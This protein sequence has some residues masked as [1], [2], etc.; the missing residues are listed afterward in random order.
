MYI[1]KS[2]ILMVVL[3]FTSVLNLQAQ[4]FI[5]E[6]T[7]L[8]GDDDSKMTAKNKAIL[9]AKRE[10]IEKA[11]VYVS[12]YSKSISGILKNDTIESFSASIMK[13]TLLENK[14]E[15][16]NY[17][18]KIEADI[19]IKLL[20]KKIEQ[21]NNSTVHVE[22]QIQSTRDEIKEYNNQLKQLIK[23]RNKKKE[24]KNLQEIKKILI[25]TVTDLAQNKDIELQLLKDKSYAY[26][27]ISSNIKDSEIYINDAY[28]GI[29]PIKHFKVQS[30]EEIT[31]KGINDKRYYPDDVIFKDKFKKLSVSEINL[32]FKKG[33]A[34]LFFIGKDNST[35]YINDTIKQKLNKDE[36]VVIVEAS[37]DLMIGIS[38]KDGCFISNED[39]W[40]NST[41]EIFFT[42]DRQRCSMIKNSLIHKGKVYKM[43][44]SPYTKRVW[45]N[46][47]LGASRVCQSFDDKSCYG[48]YFQWGRSGDGHEKANSSTTRE[49]ASSKNP[50]NSMFIISNKENNHNWLSDKENNLWQLNQINNPCP[51][52][53]RV[54]T[55]DE[56]LAEMPKNKDNFLKL[57]HAGYRYRK[58]GSLN[59]QN[60]STHIWSSSIDKGYSKSLYIDK[61][62]IEV[63]RSL[64][65][66]GYS[67][68]CIKE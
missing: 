3:I 62:T 57:P 58:D 4:I 12:S 56:L 30:D 26:L 68:R 24:L 39:V 38:H 1:N 41:Y 46:K 44:V 55:I 42:L 27:N 35:L 15:Y 25:Q 31:I 34:E 67:L 40:A 54:P 18:V 32:E 48:D 51:K 23:S 60:I 47:N 66:N 28:V 53:F 7:Y 50:K 17:W 64:R 6:A 19:D 45:L 63:D 9:I 22:D 5:Q 33:E 20:N 14:F 37:N 2:T 11:G 65:A 10:C 61:K 52:S 16:P 49:I 21:F 13:V 8:M 59:N 36:K 43:I 29:A